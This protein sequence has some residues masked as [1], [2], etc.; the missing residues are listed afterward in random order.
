MYRYLF[1]M[2]FFLSACNETEYPKVID[3]RMSNNANYVALDN[4][5]AI[6][7][8]GAFIDSLCHQ[9]RQDKPT[10]DHNYQNVFFKLSLSEDTLVQE[11]LDDDYIA[12]S[13]FFYCGY[14]CYRKT[15]TLTLSEGEILWDHHPIKNGNELKEKLK[16]FYELDT[17][18]TSKYSLP[19]RVDYRLDIAFYRDHSLEEGLF[20]LKQIALTYLE[21]KEQYPDEIPKM[22]VLLSP[23]FK[24]VPPPLSHNDVH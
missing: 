9:S 4:I 11:S 20:L 10:P 12:L 16:G 5:E 17:A 21:L 23:L 15:I 19:K 22:R 24:P 18:R 14:G 3:L 8:W 2:L 13:P 7:S 6:D 1:L